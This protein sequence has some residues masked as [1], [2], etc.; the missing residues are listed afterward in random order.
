MAVTYSQPKKKSAEQLKKER[1]EARRQAELKR[2]RAQQEARKKRQG[3]DTR[4]VDDIMSAERKADAKQ[5]A[6]TSSN[7]K[8]Q[9]ESSSKETNRQFKE[10]RLREIEKEAGWHRKEK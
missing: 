9:K 10:R 1:K 6:Q 7:Y 4:S 3:K 8:G 5:K 2:L